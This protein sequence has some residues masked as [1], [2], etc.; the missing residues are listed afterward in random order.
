MCRWVGGMRRTEPGEVG[1]GGSIEAAEGENLLSAEPLRATASPTDKGLE[2]VPIRLALIGEYAYL[3]AYLMDTDRIEIQTPEG[4]NLELTLAGLGSRGAAAII[5]TLIIVALAIVVM[6]PF[7]GR[8]GSLVMNLVIIALPISLFFGYHLVFETIGRRQSP[9]KRLLRLRVV[10]TDGSPAGGVAALIRNLVRIV[11][12]LPAFY[13]I[14][15]V[16]VFSTTQNQRLGDLAAGVVVMMEPRRAPD[17]APIWPEYT[18]V[19]EGWDV[20]AVTDEDVAMMREFLARREKLGTD[21]RRQIGF[22]I[23]DSIERK[24]SRPAGNM[25]SEQTIETVL[26]L[27]ETRD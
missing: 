7:Q 4:F 25:T 2:M 18:E 10:R 16:S 5:D 8:G 21:S 22:R 23:S 26:R 20:S 14:G 9:G 3:H 24:I 13:L 1:N 27:K 15:M 11:D 12:F 6:L 17:P 19:P